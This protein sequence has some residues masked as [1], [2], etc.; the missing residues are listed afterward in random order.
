MHNITFVCVDKMS[1][2]SI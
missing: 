2:W 1:N